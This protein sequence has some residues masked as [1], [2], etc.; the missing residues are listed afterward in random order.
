VPTLGGC[1][2][3]L[4]E[5]A[6][7]SAVREAT[8]TSFRLTGHDPFDLVLL[9]GVDPNGVTVTGPAA[10]R[11]VPRHANS[12]RGDLGRDGGV[13]YSPLAHE[14]VVIIRR[15]ASGTWHVSSR[16]G[17]ITSLEVLD[18]LPKPHVTAS[19]AA[20][21]AAAGGAM[22]HVLTYRL[23]AIP[24]QRVTFIE[25]GPSGDRTLGSTTRTTGRL[26]FTS[27]SGPGGVRTIEALVDENGTPRDM[28][29]VARYRAAAARALAAPAKLVLRRRGSSLV[30]SWRPVASASAYAITLSSIH[31]R[32]ETRVLV[33]R[34][35][36]EVTFTLDVSHPAKV[37]VI[38][39]APDRTSKATVAR[40]GPGHPAA[41]RL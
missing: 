5:F 38:A 34:A 29:I 39:T 23:R 20:T 17:A 12:L 15:P 16:T 7:P 24:G 33:G 30:A 22:T 14:T 40:I 31:G 21:A 3:A 11:I 37:V 41:V 28:I 4:N 19:L 18:G 2:T 25:H 26:R 13:Y 8:S 9:K 35:A 6:T 10:R 32:S 36:T 27:A 1:D